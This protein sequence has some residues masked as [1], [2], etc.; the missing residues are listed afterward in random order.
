MLEAV[1]NERD[2]GESERQPSNNNNNEEEVVIPDLQDMKKESLIIHDDTSYLDSPRAWICCLGCFLVYFALV[3]VTFAFGVFQRYYLA[4][5]LADNSALSMIGTVQSAMIQI[6]GYF[7][8]ILAERI[9][10]RPTMLIGLFLF[11]SSLVLSSFATT[12]WELV[13]TYGIIGGIGGSFL[14]LPSVSAVSSWFNVRLGLALGLGTAGSGLGGVIWSIVVAKLIYAFGTA[15]AFRIL[16]LT[17]GLILLIAIACVKEAPIAASQKGS[18]LPSSKILNWRFGMLSVAGFIMNFAFLVPYF[19]IPEFSSTLNMTETEGAFMLSLFNVGSTIGRVSGGLLADSRLGPLNS[20]T[21]AVFGSSLSTFIL[22]PLSRTREIFT[23]FVLIS[24]L[25]SGGLISLF[26]NVGTSV[27]GADNIAQLM[28]LLFTPWF[29]GEFASAPIFGA[30][31][32]YTG[33]SNKYESYL[34]A[35]YYVG[36]IYVV[37]LVFTVALR[38]IVNHAEGLFPITVLDDTVKTV[39]LEKTNTQM[40]K[41]KVNKKETAASRKGKDP[42]VSEEDDDDEDDDHEEE[43]KSPPRKLRGASSKESKRD[44]E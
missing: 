33:P 25:C 22:W 14:D 20:F 32:D 24:G 16:A 38:L 26:F 9:G 3:G 39:E 31:I 34:P 1:V 4:E 2:L 28:G 15:W 8:G 13:L 35:I 42:A 17:T 7:T 40:V 18:K 41:A 10:Y 5:G 30:I 44:E 6:V 19:Y 36:T 12:V 23:A 43:T 37:S 27:F 11:V 21:I 29:I